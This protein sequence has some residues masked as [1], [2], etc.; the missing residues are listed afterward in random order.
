MQFIF[1]TE[2]LTQLIN[3]KIG[4]AFVI[5]EIEGT[6]YMKT[7][8]ERDNAILIL[9]LSSGVLCMGKKECKVIPLEIPEIEV[10][11]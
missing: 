4:Q 11:I 2:G 5:P 9:N 1:K 3:L 7:D 10:K 6:V 8:E